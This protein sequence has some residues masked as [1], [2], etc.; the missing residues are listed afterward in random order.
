M[1]LEYLL[2]QYVVRNSKVV[3]VEWNPELSI[4][5]PFDYKEK[6]AKTAHHMLLIASVTE[7]FLTGR[8]ENA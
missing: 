3:N 7:T 8:S 5:N 4:E 1:S 6:P 2:E